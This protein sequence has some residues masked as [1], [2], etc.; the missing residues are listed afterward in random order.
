M[1]GMKYMYKS[2]KSCFCDEIKNSKS[3]VNDVTDYGPE[4]FVINIEQATVQNDAFRRALWTGNHLQLTLMSIPPRSEIGLEIH[5]DVDQ[6]LRL[7]EG[8]GLVK[9]GHTR[10]T[11]DYQEC[12]SDNY[13]ILV[14]AGI[15]HNIIN[16]GNRPLKIYSIYAPPHHPHGTVHETRADALADEG[17]H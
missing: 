8:T 2:I 11:L 13:V 12:I 14:P 16:T 6:F 1:K 4:P 7:E 5:N 10:D 17:N 3:R 15:W 9:M